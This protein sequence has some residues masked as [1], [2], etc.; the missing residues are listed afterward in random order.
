M[1]RGQKLRDTVAAAV[2]KL[3]A[4]GVETA[5]GD[6]RLLVAQALGLDR[7]GLTL[8]RERLLTAAET[9]A[10]D[11]LVDRRAAREPVS[12]ILGRREF[13]SLSFELGPDTLDPRP[14][15][16]TLVEAALAA[17]PRRDGAYRVLDIGT[18]SG[19]LLIA[20]LS[21][22]SA[23]VGV[24]TDIAEGALALA[25][26]NAHVTRVGDRARFVRAHWADGVA[27]GFDLVI[28]NPPY[29][30]ETQWPSL[31]PEVRD[32]DPPRAL[33]AGRDGLDAYRAIATRLPDLLRPD[34]VAVIELGQ[35]QADAARTLFSAAGMAVASVVRD[36]AG[37]E[38]ALVLR[39]LHD[40]GAAKK[41][42]GNPRR[43]R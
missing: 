31:E 30:A 20:F 25:R 14:D 2:R 6:A 23:A 24:G 36:L 12:R 42:V 21:E 37:T 26:R 8:A 19:C 22:R 38:R 1:N 17:C 4:A 7:G 43:L 3:R 29:V 9:R 15:S 11:A 10:I 27:G 41:S 39:P 28:A 13:W 35:G 34:G 32:H 16:E 40:S 5:E 33:L 18:G